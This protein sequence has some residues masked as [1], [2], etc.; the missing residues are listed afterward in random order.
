MQNVFRRRLFGLTL[1][2]AMLVLAIGMATFAATPAQADIVGPPGDPGPTAPGPQPTAIPDRDG[3]TIPDSEDGCPDAFGPPWYRNGCPWVDSD[4]DGRPDDE[5][6][7]DYVYG[8]YDNYGCPWPTATP[9]PT[10][11]PPTAPPIPTNAPP[12]TLPPTQLPQTIFNASTYCQ[13]D[14][15]VEF[16]VEGFFQSRTIRIRGDV[17]FQFEVINGVPTII[18]STEILTPGLELLDG[19]IEP[20]LITP[21]IQRYYPPGY[22][23]GYSVYIDIEGGENATIGLPGGLAISL[24]RHPQTLLLHQCAIDLSPDGT[25]QVYDV[26]IHSGGLQSGGGRPGGGVGHDPVKTPPSSD[27]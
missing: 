24:G 27:S 14:F 19:D 3:D 23:I 4:G 9:I 5:D 11:P 22:E 12:T 7:C 16:G 15:E 20:L 2:G 13:A 10:N 17:T 8:P 6:N 26:G 1:I 21:S 18:S 25:Y